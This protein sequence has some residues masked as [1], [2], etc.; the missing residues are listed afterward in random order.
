ME[1]CLRPDELAGSEMGGADARTIHRNIP[2]SADA[3][4]D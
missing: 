1:L 2:S 4:C 3:S